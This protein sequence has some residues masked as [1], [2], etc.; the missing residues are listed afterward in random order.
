MS[1]FSRLFKVGQAGANKVLDKLESPEL[2]LE[3]AIRDKEKQ[4][5][6]AK[7]SVSKCIATERQTKALLEKERVQASD[8]ELKAEAALRADNEELAAK[9]LARST[10]YEAK[11]NEL[12]AN[13][14]SQREQVDELKGVI[15]KMDDELAEYK[16][17]KD[18]IL[19]QSRAA[20]VKKKMYDARARMTKKSNSADDLMERIRAKAERKSFEADA[21]REMAESFGGGDSLEKE[22]EGLEGSVTTS[23]VQD[24]LA[25][26]KQRVGKT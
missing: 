6:E 24:K 3:Q 17:N 7:Q 11:A 9:A 14:E 1:I 5:R 8:W 26:L 4:V 12:Q 20:D 10:E 22:F 25:A 15:A 18:F 13:W 2:M 16:R 19:A 21:S 23:T